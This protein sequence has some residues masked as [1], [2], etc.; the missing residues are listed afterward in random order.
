MYSMVLSE[1]MRNRQ[2]KR[3]LN[4]KRK[5]QQ[6]KRIKSELTKGQQAANKQFSQTWP[7]SGIIAKVELQDCTMQF[8]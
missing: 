5:K 6:T 3:A 2:F 7:W 4:V 1:S 8:C